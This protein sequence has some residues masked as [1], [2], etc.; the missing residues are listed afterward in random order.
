MRKTIFLSDSDFEGQDN[1]G[2]MQPITMNPIGKIS[3]VYRLCVGTPR[4]GL[5]APNSR[6]RIDLFPDQISSDSIIGLD[7]FSHIWIL[8]S[9]H[10]NSSSKKKQKQKT[11]KISPPALGGKKKVGVFASR[12]PH[13]PCNIGFTL[14]KVDS[15]HIPPKKIH[16]K[17][18]KQPYS[19]WVSG[20]DLVDG[21]P[22]LDIKPYV[23]HYDSPLGFQDSSS[24]YENNDVNEIEN[25]NEDKVDSVSVPDWIKAGLD[26]R[27]KVIF[28]QKAEQQLKNILFSSSD[29]KYCEDDNDDNIKK[30]PELQFYGVSSG[31]DVSQEQAHEKIKS[32]IQEVLGVDVRSSFQTKNLRK[33]KYRAEQTRRISN[34]D[35]NNE[36][37]NND[38]KRSESSNNYEEL[39]TE[40]TIDVVEREQKILC[41]QQI[42]NLLIKFSVVEE[43]NANNNNNNEHVDTTG[44][45]ADDTI[46][47]HEI[48]YIS[49]GVKQERSKQHT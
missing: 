17:A 39:K 9:F 16:T 27:R 38:N 45:G 33:G 23:P 26:K 20:L 1:N 22:V 19:V 37:N 15:I 5:L 34:D 2:Y 44:S 6:G 10:L 21:T 4:Q 30:L 32:C 11:S 14:A 47:I 36:K 8:F 41:T 28:Q 43:V 7:E 3:S 25:N 31:R 12:S 35:N 46:I 49:P 48:E 24:S 13:R 40:D 42:D 29:K 18:S